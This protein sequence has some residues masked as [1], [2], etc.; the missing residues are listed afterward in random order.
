MYTEKLHGSI[1]NMD[2]AADRR[3]AARRREERYRGAG[4]LLGAARFASPEG[5]GIALG[6][7]RSLD[8]ER[9]LQYSCA[10]HLRV[11]SGGAGVGHGEQA[12]TSIA[13]HADAH[14]EPFGSACGIGT[15]SKRGRRRGRERE[16]HHL[17]VQP[18][19]RAFLAVP[20]CRYVRGLRND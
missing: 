11:Q 3:T 20:A 2:C 6:R 15:L 13:R 17:H 1:F 8:A 9:P 18:E 14:A 16:L 10:S 4:T 12:H 19:G 5:C 7:R